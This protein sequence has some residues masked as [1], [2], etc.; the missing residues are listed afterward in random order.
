MSRSIQ[1]W[2]FV[3]PKMS[4]DLSEYFE[5]ILDFIKDDP[6]IFLHAFTFA[7]SDIRTIADMD[8]VAARVA[9]LL[10][11]RNCRA[12]AFCSSHAPYFTDESSALLKAYRRQIFA[13]TGQMPRL[14][15]PI[16]TLNVNLIESE[17]KRFTAW[18]A[19]VP[20]PCG[21][22]VHGDDVAR[23][24]LDACRLK[25]IKVPDELRVVGTGNSPLYCERTFPTLS[26]YAIDH[27]KAATEAA[28]TLR[29]LI[30]EKA[31]PRKASYEIP[32]SDVTERASSVDA[33]GSARR[34]GSPGL[35]P[36]DLAARS[37]ADI[38]GHR[39]SSQRLDP[40]DRKRLLVHLQAHA[41]KR[42]LR[43]AAR[44]PLPRP[45]HLE[46]T[47]QNARR[48]LRIRRHV[49]GH[50]RLQSQVRPDDERISGNCAS[51]KEQPHVIGAS[52]PTPEAGEVMLGI[53]SST[54]FLHL[55]LPLL[56]H[57]EI[58]TTLATCTAL[59]PAS[60]SSAS[61][62]RI[63]ASGLTTGR[64]SDACTGSSLSLF[65][66]QLITICT[67]LSALYH[68]SLFCGPRGPSHWP[69]DETRTHPTGS[70][71]HCAHNEHCDQN[72]S[73]PYGTPCRNPS[74]PER[75]LVKAL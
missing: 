60:G 20:K 74:A 56:H 45:S 59:S 15:R 28:R 72:E 2:A 46:R 62:R 33:R 44:S 54:Y 11:R 32:L 10:V 50:P 14:F 39:V 58:N 48:P 43:T 63:L 64:Y 69:Y 29:R 36:Q 66:S 24:M 25:G 42:D 22:F 37:Y 30:N 34:A 16:S 3:A 70:Y 57:G 21:M 13:R 73:R 8:G 31:S 12:Y 71:I 17:V 68:Y 4:R 26:S 9:D 27:H 23:K 6:S 41:T 5:G 49:S 47:D 38:S 61:P 52:N 53:S 65:G 35:H 55:P 75:P 40:Q 67:H 19:K 1:N 7:D 18:C 51:A